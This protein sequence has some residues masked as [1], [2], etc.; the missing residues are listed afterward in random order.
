MYCLHVLCQLCIVN[1]TLCSAE[2]Q[3]L[4]QFNSKKFQFNFITFSADIR[5]FNRFYYPESLGIQG[6]TNKKKF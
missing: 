3:T 2:Q 5:I 1:V 4:K 6:R